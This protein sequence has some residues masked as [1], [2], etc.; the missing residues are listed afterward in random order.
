MPERAMAQSARFVNVSRQ[1]AI[2]NSNGGGSAM[3]TIDAIL[4]QHGFFEK[5]EPRHLE[6]LVACARFARFNKNEYI[7]R[8]DRPAESFYVIGPGRIAIELPAPAQRTL[9]IQTLGEGEILGWSWLYP[10]YRWQFD[11]RAIEPTQT[12]A[13]DAPRLRAQCE[14]DHELGYQLMKRFAH[15]MTQR[16]QA[17]RLQLLDV[18]A[19]TA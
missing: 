10:P 14:R 13:I 6:T 17:T 4:A 11:A 18:Y 15:V 12:I 3:L 19:V 1:S 16:L 8:I 7:F 5:M 9:P 2:V